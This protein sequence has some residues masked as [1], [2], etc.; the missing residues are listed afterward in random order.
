MIVGDFNAVSNQD[1]K[2][3]GIPI[4]CNDVNDFNNMISRIGLIDGGFSGRKYTWCNNR[5]G[6][7]CILK[8][9]DR[10]LLNNMCTAIFST[11]ITHLNISCSDHS[12][13]LLSV[14]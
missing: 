13:L 4:N 5:I 2:L 3:G 6:S 8:R 9:L 12:S 10:C 11:G 7:A 1:E 14:G